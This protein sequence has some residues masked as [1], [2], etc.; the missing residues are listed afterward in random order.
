MY[1]VNKSL[2][3]IEPLEQKFFSPLG[4]RE[5]DH[6]QEWIAKRPD[7][8]GEDLLIIQKEFSGFD[9]TKERLDLLAL[10]KQ[11]V[12]VII[13]NKLDDSGRNV[14]WQALKYT[15][16]CSRLSKA[17][18]AKIYQQYLDANEP[19]QNAEERISDFM[20]GQDF[21]ELTLNEGISQRIILI[22]SKFRKEVTST[23]LWL[24]NF[25]VR[26]QCFHT[27]L[28]AMDDN[29]FLKVEQIIPT[30]DTEDYAIGM[31][32][33]TQEDIESKAK[34]KTRHV[35]REDFWTELIPKMNAKQTDLFRNISPSIGSWIGAGSGIRSVPFVLT[36]TKSYCSAQ[37]HID[38]RD[39][40]DNKRIFDRLIE[41]QDQVESEFGGS[42][43]W[44]RMDEHKSCRIEAKSA[45]NVFDRDQWETMIDF[46]TDAMF[47]LE[48]ALKEPLRQCSAQKFAVG[49]MQ[50]ISLARQ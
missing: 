4:L 31:A 30:Q 25:K 12:L 27:E 20:D 1:K 37:L 45:G 26:I 13:E 8:L 6:L 28:F 2:N 38:R 34:R 40:S 41:S 23:V 32:E 11:G 17:N 24:M 35:L 47:R 33:K 19:G 15:S 48:R 29:L 18:I 42:L 14:T 39:K 22:A 46:M 43:E 3:S 50:G 49:M 10:D 9:E 16:Y 36:V 21:E 7:V 44:K 5:R